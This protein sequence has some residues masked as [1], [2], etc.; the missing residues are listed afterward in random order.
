MLGGAIALLCNF[1][2]LAANV[3]YVGFKHSNF[4]NPRL[5]AL[6]YHRAHRL[7]QKQAEVG[8]HD[9]T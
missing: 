5:F 8:E 9:C 1:G 3:Y 7:V 4:E 6:P 2:T